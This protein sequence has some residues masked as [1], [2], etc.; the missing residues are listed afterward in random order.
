MKKLDLSIRPA[1]PKAQATEEPK[2]VVVVT[3]V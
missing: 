1:Q 2:K 3:S